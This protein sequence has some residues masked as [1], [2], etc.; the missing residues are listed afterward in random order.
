MKTPPLSPE[1]LKLPDHRL[2]GLVLGL[3][4]MAEAESRGLNIYHIP[5]EIA[6]QI[7]EKYKHADAI[8]SQYLRVEKALREAANGNFA[9]AGRLIK[10]YVRNIE[11]DLAIFNRLIQELRA[12][13][14]GRKA[15]GKKTA[16]L[17]KANLLERNQRIIKAAAE[18]EA[19]N[20][21]PRSI[22]AKLERRF[23]VSAGQI[24]RII[25]NSK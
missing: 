19:A 24:R 14:K 18:L 6:V 17:R 15:G 4:V 20:Y 7:V 16:E 25:K 3:C 11:A 9:T 23:P 12:K 21:D 2:G 10:D 8:D 13:Q 5:E 22:V 1:D